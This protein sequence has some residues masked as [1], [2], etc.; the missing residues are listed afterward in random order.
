[1]TAVTVSVREADAR[2]I[3]DYA[4]VSIAFDVRE[5]FDCVDDDSAPGGIALIARP[6]EHSYIK[7]YDAIAEANPTGWPQRFAGSRWALLFARADGEHAGGALVALGDGKDDPRGATLWDIRVSPS[8]R[9]AGVGTAL[10]KRAAVWAADLGCRVLDAETQNINVAACRFYRR[11]GCFLHVANRT[12]YP[13]CPDEVQ[14]IWR[15]TL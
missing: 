12:A 3:S 15:K 4:R 6:L 8:K 5:V 7:D 9:R 2:A 1:M 10:F 14:L 13:S 11:Q